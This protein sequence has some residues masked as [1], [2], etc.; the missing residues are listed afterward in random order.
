VF[1]GQ[2][3]LN[4]KWNGWFLTLPQTT[5]FAPTARSAPDRF[6]KTPGHRSLRRISR[7]RALAWS[8]AMKLL[9]NT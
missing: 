4:V 5:V 1:S 7:A 3:M 8:I 9:A 2:H 6:T